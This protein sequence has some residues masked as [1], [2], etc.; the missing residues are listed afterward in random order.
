MKMVFSFLAGCALM[1]AFMAFPKESRKVVKSGIDATTNMVAE[2][3]AAAAKAA[4]QQ[5]AQQK[6]GH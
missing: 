1:Y 5:L 2:G 4:D 3:T 6:H